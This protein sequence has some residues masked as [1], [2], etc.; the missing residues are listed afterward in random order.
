M[1]NT[2]LILYGFVM[3][4]IDI[5]MESI[6][7]YYNIT[8]GTKTIAIIIAMLIYAIQPILF[9]KA[10]KYEGM[11]VTNV[12][13]NVVSTGLIVVIGAVIFG[14][15]INAYKCSGIILSIISLLLLSVT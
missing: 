11:G 13:W 1:F 8:G 15:K 12:V 4:I 2:H 3:S 9:S 14:E 10:L 5:I 7:K 6:C